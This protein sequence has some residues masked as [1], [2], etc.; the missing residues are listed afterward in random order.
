MAQQDQHDQ[1]KQD[2]IEGIPNLGDVESINI[3]SA[4]CREVQEQERVVAQHKDSTRRQDPLSR[5]CLKIRWMRT[6]AL[7]RHQTPGDEV[8]LC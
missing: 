2:T 1:G 3:L 4:M 8:G 5:I 6:L 7:M